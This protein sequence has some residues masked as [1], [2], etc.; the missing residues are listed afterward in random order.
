MSP[1]R[2]EPQAEWLSAMIRAGRRRGFFVHGVGNAGMFA[3]PDDAGMRMRAR[4]V[5][6]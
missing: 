3:G 1:R 2:P 5:W 6:G 4:V